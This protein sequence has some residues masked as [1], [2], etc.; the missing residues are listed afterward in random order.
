MRE[1]C[2]VHATEEGKL[3]KWGLIL[4]VKCLKRNL[5]LLCK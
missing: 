4:N 1:I 3:S 2:A 5:K